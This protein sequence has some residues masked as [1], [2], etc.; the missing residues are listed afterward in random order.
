MSLVELDRPLIST[1]E[2]AR[3]TGVSYRQ[4]DY[5]VTHGVFGDDVSRNPGSGNPRMFP[6]DLMPHLATLGAISRSLAYGNA[7][8]NQVTT[9]FMR[10][11]VENFDTG[12]IDLGEGIHLTWDG[13]SNTTPIGRNT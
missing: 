5:W 1:V 8:A 6:A 11:V 9:A 4:L 13:S 3:K 10:Q 12:Y 7:N 2:A